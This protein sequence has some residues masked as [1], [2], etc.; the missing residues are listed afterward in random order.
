VKVLSFV[1]SAE[2]KENCFELE[3]GIKGFFSDL[4]IFPIKVFSSLF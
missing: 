4:Q 3:G 1:L 2:K